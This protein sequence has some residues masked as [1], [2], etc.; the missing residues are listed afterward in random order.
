MSWACAAIGHIPLE[1]QANAV[2]CMA[3]PIAIVMGNWS[4]TQTWELVGSILGGI[5]QPLKGLPATL[6]HPWPRRAHG[7]VRVIDSDFAE[8][9]IP[10]FLK[11][12]NAAAHLAALLARPVL[13][14]ASH[15]RIDA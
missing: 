11:R 3:T 4:A 9:L 15:Q 12:G 8:H 1:L 5:C 6:V 2:N 10:S 7:V 14:R 13:P